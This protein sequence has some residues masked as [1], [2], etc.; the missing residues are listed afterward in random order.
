MKI[1][2]MMP[3]W[4]SRAMGSV[5]E[6]LGRSLRIS[7][8]NFRQ[9]ANWVPTVPSLREGWQILVKEVAERSGSPASA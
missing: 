2:K 4:M 7:N 8:A 6:T 9:A 5:G 1:P 3:G